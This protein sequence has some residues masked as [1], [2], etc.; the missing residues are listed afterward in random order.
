[1]TQVFLSDAT[2]GEE[3][4]ILRI[5]KYLNRETGIIV[6]LVGPPGSG[7]SFSA[8]RIATL[9]DPGFGIEN[10]CFTVPDYIAILNR[11]TRVGQAILLDEAGVMGP[12]RKWQSQ[13]N[14]SLAL[15]AE[16]VR[17]RG[18]LTLV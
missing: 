7:K 18:L 12:A 16:S 9:I 2:T 11:G 8:I 1:M 13:S 3:V 4:I 14:I 10:I 17:H 6:F 15:T 5:K